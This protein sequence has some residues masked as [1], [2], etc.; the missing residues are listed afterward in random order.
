[1]ELPPDAEEVL[2]MVIHDDV[3]ELGDD[4]AEIA[5]RCRKNAG[6]RRAPTVGGWE[7]VAT[8]VVAKRDEMVNSPFFFAAVCS[9]C[10]ALCVHFHLSSLF[11]AHFR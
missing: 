9:F 11:F 2:E 7:G 3:L 4:K 6:R 8:T 1:M 10:F 5:K